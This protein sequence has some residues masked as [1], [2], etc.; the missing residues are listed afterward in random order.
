MQARTAWGTQSPHGGAK[1][2]G[3]APSE[4]AN[5]PCPASHPGDTSSHHPC[6]LQGSPPCCTPLGVGAHNPPRRWLA[7]ATLSG[8]GTC[9][10]PLHSPH[11][12]HASS[13]SPTG[14]GSGASLC[15]FRL[16]DPCP[17]SPKSVLL[18]SR[19]GREWPGVFRPFS[20]GQ[21]AWE[22]QFPQCKMSACPHPFSVGH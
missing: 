14:E 13:T 15:P 7:T 11:L 19:S 9:M 12:F 22:P 5:L 6:R 4:L 16:P 20:T 3:N 21:Q 8:A 2:C 17:S 10:L 1:G 18:G